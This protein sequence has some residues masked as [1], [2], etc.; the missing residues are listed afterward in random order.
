MKA[1][2]RGGGCGEPGDH[3]D[4]VAN[5][6]ALAVQEPRPSI[7]SEH[8]FRGLVSGESYSSESTTVPPL[9]PGFQA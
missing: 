8:S 5:L 3:P 1:E 4:E 2:G 9:S 7:H 6:L